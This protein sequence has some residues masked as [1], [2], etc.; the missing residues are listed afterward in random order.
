MQEGSRGNAA[1]QN[2]VRP[3]ISESKTI[4]TLEKCIEI[5]LESIGGCEPRP[6]HMLTMSLLSV[7]CPLVKLSLYF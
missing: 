3:Q 1:T 7:I 2:K 4:S 6:W 5:E